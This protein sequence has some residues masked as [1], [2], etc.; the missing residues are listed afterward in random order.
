MIVGG[1]GQACQRTCTRRRAS[2]HHEATG[3]LGDHR[4]VDS[5]LDPCTDGEAAV[6]KVLLTS[7]GTKKPVTQ[8]EG[9]MDQGCVNR[10]E[11]RSIAR[12]THQGN[13]IDIEHLLTPTRAL[14]VLVTVLVAVIL[15]AWLSLRLTPSRPHSSGTAYLPLVPRPA[16]FTTQGLTT[17]NRTIDFDQNPSPEPPPPRPPSL[18]HSSTNTYH[19]PW[20]QPNPGP[21]PAKS[22]PPSPNTSSAST[23][24]ANRVG[25]AG[26]RSRAR[27]RSEP[28]AS[29]SVLKESYP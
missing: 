23:P 6:S 11:R 28:P 22:S 12:P 18:R 8:R 10:K 27:R 17:S 1:Q 4:K 9:L 20:L 19:S 24:P 21:G 15:R 25:N 14:G 29:L 26:G 13:F 5:A 3:R 16:L 2:E 7:L